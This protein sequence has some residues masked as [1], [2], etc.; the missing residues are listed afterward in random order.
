MS[1]AALR[2]ASS[3]Q[4][5]EIVSAAADKGAPLWLHSGGSK[6]R[7]GRAPGATPPLDLSALT[8]VVTY[9]P[10]ELILIARPATPLTEV[11][12]LLAQHQQHLAFEPPRWGPTA[13]LGGVIA[14]GASGSRRF[15]AGAARDFVLGME[16]VDGRGR[17]IR[18][19][20]RVV[21]NV[22]GY[23]LWR[24]MTGSYGTLGIMTEVCIKLWPQPQT[25]CTL[26][27]PQATLAAAVAHMIR[28][29][30]RPEAITGLAYEPAA[31]TLWARVEGSD[32]AVERQLETLLRDAGAGD[33]VTA[34]TSASHWAHLQ[35]CGGLTAGDDEVIF[36]LAVPPSRATEAEAALQE[37]GLRRCCLD[38][39]GGLIWAALPERSPAAEVHA[40][41]RR[42]QGM[43]ARLAASPQ[44]ANDH[45]FTPLA[46]TVARLNE[47]L[48]QT[49]DPQQLFSPGRMYRATE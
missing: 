33:V 34:D 29:S 4:V 39:A 10:E 19:G 16:F 17:V 42:L 35:E 22:T 20:G 6:Q 30:R 15:V 12:A 13:T 2:P 48:R 36:R 27:I 1:A 43:A 37:L 44:D 49:L 5:A 41:A 11:Q 14:T 45:A 24:A 9:E 46:P 31:G 21:K 18:A 38:W 8:G 26:A 23:D 25:Q 28:W 32:G 47:T 7:L 40:I 3:S